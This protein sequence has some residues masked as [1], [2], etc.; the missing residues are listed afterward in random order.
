MR[1]TLAWR[2]SDILGD[3]SWTLACHLFV[4][5]RSFRKK[6]SNEVALPHPQSRKHN[7]R[8]EDVPNSGGVVWNLVKRTINITG[9]RNAKDKVNRAKN[10]T[11]GWHD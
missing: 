4:L 1:L 9:Y 11:L 3:R 5:G 10:R 8:K 7:Y 2:S 6:F